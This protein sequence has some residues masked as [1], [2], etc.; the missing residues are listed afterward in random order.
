[1]SGDTTDQPAG[2]TSQPGESSKPSQ[3]GPFEAKDDAYF[4]YYALLSHQAQM[5]QDTVRTS[6]YQRAILANAELCFK[7]ES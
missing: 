3:L 1:M 7:G 4:T 5:L 6:I 2:P